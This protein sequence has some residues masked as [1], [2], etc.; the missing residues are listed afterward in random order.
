[1][2]NHNGVYSE[3]MSTKMPILNYTNFSYK[4]QSL[5][6]AREMFNMSIAH[7]KHL[8]AHIHFSHFIIRYK[9]RKSGRDLNSTLIWYYPRDSFFD[10]SLLNDENKYY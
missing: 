3:N 5:I 8:W 9:S 2:L 4:C 7:V 1:M 10:V 6:W